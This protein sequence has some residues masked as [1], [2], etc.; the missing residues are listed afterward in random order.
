MA[1]S[2]RLEVVTPDR[3]VLSTQVDAIQVRLTDGWWG[4]LPG[5]APFLARMLAGVL[6]YRCGEMQRY[7]ALYQGTIEVQKAGLRYRPPHRGGEAEALADQAIG[8]EGPGE[9]VDGDRV[10]VLTAAAEEGDDLEALRSALEQHEEEV[11]RLVKDA[12][13]EYMQMR[14][15]LET[16]LREASVA[17]SGRAR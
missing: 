4:I 17:E 15:A 12:K 11:M 16:A 9:S 6:R 13:L 10:L 8:A 14:L 5:H 7:V 3:V 2:L 1:E